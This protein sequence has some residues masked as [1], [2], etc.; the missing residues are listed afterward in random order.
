MKYCSYGFRQR[1]SPATGRCTSAAVE[2]AVLPASSA[3]DVPGGRYSQTSPHTAF[4]PRPRAPCTN[5]ASLPQSFSGASFPYGNTKSSIRSWLLS[6]YIR[7]VPQ[8]QSFCSISLN[9]FTLIMALSAS[10]CPFFNAFYLTELSLLGYTIIISSV[11]L[12]SD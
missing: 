8:V 7:L 9:P 12:S 10:N 5:A 11:G 2:S 4:L 3:L 1:A 6:L